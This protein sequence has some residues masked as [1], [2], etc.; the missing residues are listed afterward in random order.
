[1]GFVE[2]LIN[3]RIEEDKKLIE[4]IDEAMDVADKNNPHETERLRKIR[5][6]IAEQ[7]EALTAFKAKQYGKGEIK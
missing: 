1:M 2:N 7:L 5:K 6:V 4:E 3:K